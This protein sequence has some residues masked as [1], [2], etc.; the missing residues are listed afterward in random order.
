MRKRS[1]PV[2]LATALALTACGGSDTPVAE[3]DGALKFDPASGVAKTL[4]MPGGETVGYTAY[5]GIYYVTN[6]EDSTYQTLNYY[7]PDNA[8]AGAPILLRTYVGGYM[9]AKAME[10]SP[11]D[12]TGRALAEGYVVCIPGARGWN[13]VVTTDGA[14]VYTGRAPAALVDLKAAIRYL[15]LNDELMP[16]DAELIITDGT[17]AGG[18]MSSL[19]GATGNSPLYEPYL[20]AMGAAKARDDVYAA[21]CYCPIIDIDHADMAYEWLYGCTNDGVR[22]LNDEQKRVSAELAEAY[23]E[24]LNG[25]NLVNPTDGTALTADN[26]MDYLKTYIIASAQRARNEGLELP[27]GIGL[28]TNT[29][30]M[31]QMAGNTPSDDGK[32]KKAPKLTGREAPS[33][34]PG[35]VSVVRRQGEFVIDVDMDTYLSYVASVTALKTPP[36]FDPMGVLG[37]QP[38]PENREFGDATGSAVN[39]SRYSSNA[40]GAAIDEELAAR[41]YILNPMNFID[42]EQSDKAPHWYIRHGARDRDTAFPVPI[43]FATKLMNCGYDVDFFLPWN[44]P[45]SGDYNLDDLFLWLESIL[46]QGSI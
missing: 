28:V 39:F 30:E 10:P 44:R 41:I 24:Y 21:V 12:A 9:A 35:G 22:N 5:E 18:A 15:R 14:E 6:V 19:L 29:I 11:T 27:E 43:N 37:A 26:Y 34:G 33:F 8:S 1:F 45:H 20:E 13:S 2:M 32:A 31:P 42:G 25:L 4:T 16:G 7:V 36:A 3:N 40:N 38:S 46:P 17:S 23:P